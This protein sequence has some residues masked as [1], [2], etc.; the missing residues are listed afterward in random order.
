MPSGLFVT[1]E[2][3]EG[4]GKSS[5]A[6]RLRGSLNGLGIPVTVVREPGGTALGDKL[7][8]IL[9]FSS[10]PLTPE[11]ELLLFNA[12]RAE[13]VRQVIVPALKN[14]HVVICDRFTDSTVAYQ[15]YGRGLSLDI[16]RSV[17][18]AATGDLKPDITIL[19]DISPEEGLIR[20]TS[21]RDRFE[22]DFEKP[23]VIEFHRKI[24][25]GYLDLAAQNT[26]GWLVFDAM[27]SE[28]DV[29]NRIWNKLLPS[30]E[31]A[32]YIR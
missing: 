6:R 12:S 5:Q 28:E 10:I 13:L 31:N 22:S 30:L 14:G 20:N 8:R 19:L 11:A 21:A 3:C 24:R 7:R 29:A 1:L 32:G 15:G 27:C 16:V 25:Q 23:D 2:G 4:S 17:N 26:Q 9:K 18:T